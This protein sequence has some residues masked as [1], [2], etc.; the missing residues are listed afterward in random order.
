MLQYRIFHWKLLVYQFIH[1]TANISPLMICILWGEVSWLFNVIINN[2]SVKYVTAHR[3]AGRM[4]KLYTPRYIFEGNTIPIHI[5]YIS[6][7]S[8]YRY[9]CFIF[10]RFYANIQHKLWTVSI[11][12]KQI[13][14]LNKLSQVMH[15][16]FKNHVKLQLNS[17]Y[18]TGMQSRIK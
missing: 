4:K 11:S 8:T 16:T 6:L 5:L 9:R 14:K 17:K 18:I 7:K 15:R 10:C 1:S 2:I 12:T 13:I 3:C